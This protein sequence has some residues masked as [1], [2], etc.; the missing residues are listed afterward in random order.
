MPDVERA[1]DS[2]LFL[3]GLCLEKE[4]IHWRILLS[5]STEEQSLLARILRVV[6][7]ADKTRP[8]DYGKK[9][10]VQRENQVTNS[11]SS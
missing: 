1:N 5:L 3:C 4:R 6:E 8:K 11:V 2:R 10:S 7:R 9:P